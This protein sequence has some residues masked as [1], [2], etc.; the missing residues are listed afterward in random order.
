M[1]AALFIL[2]ALTSLGCVVLLW[3]GYRRSGTRLLMWSALCFAGLTV[4]N[5]VLVVDRLVVH[6]IDLWVW[7][8]V[9]ALLGVCALLFGL[10]WD[11]A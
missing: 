2:C 7:R 6:D 9:P 11:D 1:I 3:R 10:V 5:V 8:I 4:N